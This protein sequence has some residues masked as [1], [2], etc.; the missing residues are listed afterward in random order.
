MC[1]CVW[2]CV[3][4]YKAKAE[5]KKERSYTGVW[6]VK[7]NTV[8][9]YIT[10]PAKPIYPSTF[11]ISLINSRAS[12]AIMEELVFICLHL[13]FSVSFSAPLWTCFLFLS[14]SAFFLEL[15]YHVP[16]FFSSRLFLSLPGAGTSV[17]LSQLCPL[18]LEGA[19]VERPICLRGGKDV[20]G[21][22]V[23][24]LTHT[25]THTHHGQRQSKTTMGKGEDGNYTCYTWRRW[26][27]LCS[28]GHSVHHSIHP[29]YCG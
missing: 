1:T 21:A 4:L 13:S 9:P 6:P 17:T 28:P 12:F 2:L 5:R 29:L 3:V 18:L 20:V 15:F 11:V 25:H 24:S 26:S 14:P 7:V 8:H 19:L 23:L 27:A 22:A 10:Y 16:S